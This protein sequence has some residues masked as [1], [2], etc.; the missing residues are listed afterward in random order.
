M[1]DEKSDLEDQGISRTVSFPS[2]GG[3]IKM[4]YRSGFAHVYHFKELPEHRFYRSTVSW[5]RGRIILAAS[6]APLDFHFLTAA[7]EPLNPPDSWPTARTGVPPILGR[8]QDFLHRPWH[9]K[10]RTLQ[11]LRSGK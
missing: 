4:A 11:R 1:R 7:P 3:L 6:N 2:E 9:Q 8:I 10:M 5:K